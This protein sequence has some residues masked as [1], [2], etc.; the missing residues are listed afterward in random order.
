MKNFSFN[1]THGLGHIVPTIRPHS[2][3]HS[4]TSHDE[5]FCTHYRASN[6]SDNNTATC[7][8]SIARST[9]LDERCGLTDGQ[10]AVVPTI[11]RHA[12]YPLHVHSSLDGR[13]ALT[14]GPW[15]IVPTKL[16]HA[17]YPFRIRTS[18]GASFYTQSRGSTR[19]ANKTATCRLSIAHSHL[20]WRKM[21][22]HS[23]AITHSA[24]N[25]TTCLISIAHSHYSWRTVLHSL[26]GQDP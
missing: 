5:R 16:T 14:D 7:L 26:M 9:S 1:I 22:N 23:R 17:V 12:V 15:P 24:H 21:C 19:S 3:Y 25:T 2:L 6:R 18:L 8:I 20:S 11:R 13:C 10:F 4:H